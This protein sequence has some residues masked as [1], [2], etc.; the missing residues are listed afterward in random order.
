VKISI[1]V[2]AFNEQKLISSSLQAINKA[3]AAFE[4]LKW[5]SE[6]IV[7]D[8]NSSDRTAELARAEGATVVFEPINQIGRAR[9]RG[10][11]EATGDWIIFIDADSSPSQELFAAYDALRQ[12]R[13][14]SLPELEIQY[15]DFATWERQ[16]D[17]QTRVAEQLAYRLFTKFVQQVSSGNLVESFHQ[18]SP[19]TPAALHDFVHRVLRQASIRSA[20]RVGA[21]NSPVPT[22]WHLNPDQITASGFKTMRQRQNMKRSAICIM[23]GPRAAV[24]SPKRAFACAACPIQPFICVSCKT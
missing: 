5:E 2:P 14:V 22:S 1:V 21:S 11:A 20:K 3:S 19:R 24:N 23:R 13:P 10:A 7:C 16:P 15:A 18:P 8:N 6:L 12:K 17:N 4:R 9:N